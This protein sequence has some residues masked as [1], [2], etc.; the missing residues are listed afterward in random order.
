MRTLTF[1]P[2]QGDFLFL[3]RKVHLNLYDK[4]FRTTHSKVYNE[5]SM[6]TWNTKSQDNTIGQ[7]HQYDKFLSGY[8]SKVD[9]FTLNGKTY[10]VVGRYYDPVTDKYELD[11]SV[12]R[13]NDNK[14]NKY[15]FNVFINY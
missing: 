15:P 2:I 12:L 10:A 3:Y 9:F 11:C 4:F 8:V 5:I 7:F 1:F 13:F 14:V 6:M